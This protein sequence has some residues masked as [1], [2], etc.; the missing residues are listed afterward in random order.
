MTLTHLSIPRRRML[1]A[2]LGAAA[3]T[4]PKA[5]MARTILQRGMSGGGLAQLEG[6]EDPRLVNFG[7]FASAVQ[8]PEG[9]NLVLGSV[10]WIEAG[11]DLRLESIEVTSCVPMEER[12]DGAEVRGRMM[13][14]GVAVDEPYLFEGDAPSEREFDVEV[15]PDALWVMGDHR[16]DS[17]DS[18]AH[19]GDPRGGMVPVD[20]VVGRMVAVVGLPG[21]MR[22]QAGVEGAG[23]HEGMQ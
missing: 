20:Q 19:L 6:G 21:T 5:V 4:L 8:L 17:A 10:Q 3:L 14:N 23:G 11:T 16:S 15:P 1:A 9:Q 18:R 12:P 22:G 13:V 2:G 7:L